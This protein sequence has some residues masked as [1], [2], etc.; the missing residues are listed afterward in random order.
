[1]KK[2]FLFAMLLLMTS[3][4]AM[5]DTKEI[6]RGSWVDLYIMQDGPFANYRI[7]H[8]PPNDGKI[9]YQP[10]AV[11]TDTEIAYCNKVLQDADPYCNIAYDPD[12]V[13]QAWDE[14]AQIRGQNLTPE[15]RRKWLYVWH[16]E[17]YLL[18]RFRSHKVWLNTQSGWTLVAR[19]RSFM[20]ALM[21]H[22]ID[23]VWADSCA[24]I[25]ID[26]GNTCNYDDTGRNS[27]DGNEKRMIDELHDAV[28][29][30]P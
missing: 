6:R 2:I 9:V 3:G 1:M 8:V 7:I 16:F 24:T 27:M 12:P 26:D 29:E 22:G 28:I 20:G 25:M 13:Y 30:L 18:Q 5:A 14:A 21:A 10:S 15:N 17:N 19:H 11:N 23:D 4:A